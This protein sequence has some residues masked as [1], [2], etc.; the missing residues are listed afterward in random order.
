[1]KD[2][3]FACKFPIETN[4]KSSLIL[5]LERPKNDCEFLNILLVLQLPFTLHEKTKLLI[6]NS[7]VIT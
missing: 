7:Y 3:L 1:M 2:V 4:L 6:L 5:K